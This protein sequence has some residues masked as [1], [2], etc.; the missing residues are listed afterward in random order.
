LDE[1]KPLNLFLTGHRD[2]TSWGDLNGMFCV[3][4]STSVAEAACYPTQYLNCTMSRSITGTKCKVPNR[5]K[6]SAKHDKE[7]ERLLQLMSSTEQNT[8]EINTRI[9]VNLKM[10]HFLR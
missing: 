5:R 10:L 2:L 9:K 8:A 7:I 6:R 3:C 1:T 4:S